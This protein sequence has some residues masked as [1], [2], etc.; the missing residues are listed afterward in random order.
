MTTTITRNAQLMYQP[1]TVRV[2]G[3]GPLHPVA[4]VEF[5]VEPI[6]RDVARAHLELHAPGGRVLMC[7]KRGSRG[8]WIG[9]RCISHPSQMINSKH[10]TYHFVVRAP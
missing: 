2:R 4:Q 8:G 9:L 7:G 10:A 1:A 3:A 5:Q 6:R